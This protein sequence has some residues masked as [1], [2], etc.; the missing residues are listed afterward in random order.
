MNEQYFECG[1]Y[2][3]LEYIKQIVKYSTIRPKTV[4]QL[5][6]FMRD[7]YHELKD[8]EVYFNNDIK[9]FCLRDK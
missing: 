3:A 2:T 6:D 8:K 4:V 9:R 1:F 5:L 7:N